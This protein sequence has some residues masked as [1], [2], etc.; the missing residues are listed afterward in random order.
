M[1][2]LSVPLILRQAQDERRVDK[3][4]NERG[5]DRLRTSGE[6]TVSERATRIARGEPFDAR[7]EPVEDRALRTCLSNHELH[8]LR[9]NVIG[10]AP[11]SMVP[12]TVIGSNSFSMRSAPPH[13]TL[14][15]ALI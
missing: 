7:S 8:A 5:V 12:G 15:F 10:F 13:L 6:S 4:R 9:R 2:I 3:L 14:P 1:Y 11:T